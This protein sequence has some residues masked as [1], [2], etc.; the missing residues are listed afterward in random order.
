MDE[1][2]ALFGAVGV[3]P[4]LDVPGLSWCGRVGIQ[5]DVI[6][7]W[8][9]RALERVWPLSRGR[10]LV[11]P[12]MTDKNSARDDTLDSED[13]LRMKATAAWHGHLRR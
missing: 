9:C 4:K 13:H 10:D 11:E 3:V 7:L 6:L 8:E 12:G 1:G 2:L 5:A